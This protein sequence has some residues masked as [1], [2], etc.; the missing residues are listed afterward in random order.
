MEDRK[1]ECTGRGTVLR[2]YALNQMFS[3]SDTPRPFAFNT[4]EASGQGVLSIVTL[5][6]H[7]SITYTEDYIR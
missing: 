6:T 2:G 3:E 7:I 1:A 4:F 5:D